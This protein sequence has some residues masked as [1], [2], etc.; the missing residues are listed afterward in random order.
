MRSALIKHAGDGSCTPQRRRCSAST[1]MDREGT[2]RN[3]I[4]PLD[5]TGGSAS[6]QTAIRRRHLRQTYDRYKIHRCRGC[7]RPDSSRKAVGLYSFCQMSITSSS[8]TRTDSPP[9][10]QP[11]T[12]LYTPQACAKNRSFAFSVHRKGRLHTVPVKLAS[13]ARGHF[14]FA[15]K[16]SRHA[17]SSTP[18]LRSLLVG[19]AYFFFPSASNCLKNA[20]RSLVF[21]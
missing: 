13:R 9:D 4:T 1:S 2:Y 6:G 8:G 12:N 14:R 18:S 17:S 5:R 11:R 10:Q 15:A 19:R 20:T 3:W 21:C 16:S 7:M